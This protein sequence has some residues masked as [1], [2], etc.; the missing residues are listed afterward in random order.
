MLSLVSEIH[1]WSS[2]D[3]INVKNTDYGAFSYHLTKDVGNVYDSTKKS[4]CEKRGVAWNLT[5]KRPHKLKDKLKELDDHLNQSKI[6]FVSCK[7]AHVYLL[8]AK[9]ILV[10]ILY[11]VQTCDLISISFDKF[12]STKIQNEPVCDGYIDN[13]HIVAVLS[14]GRVF[15]YGGSWREGWSIEGG[16]RRYVYLYGE[17]MVV[18]GRS[19]AEHPQ[20]WSPLTKDHQRANLHLYWVGSRGSDLLSYKK[21]SAEPIA[22]VISKIYSKNLIVVEQNV[23]QRGAVSVE[24][25]VLELINNNLKRASVTAVPLQTQV[26]STS[27]SKNEIYLLLCCID[28]SIALLNRNRGSTKI[29][30][31]S[32]IPTLACWHDSNCL[33]AIGNENGQIQYIDASLNFVRTQIST[34]DF[35]PTNI[36]DVSSYFNTRPNVTLLKWEGKDL[37]LCLEHGPLI[38]VTHDRNSLHFLSVIQRYL[39]DGKTDKAVN[40]LLSWEFNEECFAALQKIVTYLLRLPLTEENAQLLQNALG[41]YYSPPIPLDAEAIHNY[42]FQVKCLTRRFFYQ[43]IRA[44][45]FETAFL[46]AVDIGHHDLFMDL[47]YIAVKMG[48]TEMA[49]AARAQASTLLSSCSS[50]ASD[51]SRSSC[52]QCSNSTSE[53]SSEELSETEDQPDVQI[54]PT[55][56]HNDNYLTT[57][58]NN[59]NP[60]T[61]GSYI[62]PIPNLDLPKVN[63]TK[64]TL[65]KPTTYRPFPSNQVPPLPVTAPPLPVPPV[66]SSVNEQFNNGTYQ[67]PQFSYSIPSVP[68][69]IQT[70]PF[71]FTIPNKNFRSYSFT[72]SN[73]ASESQKPSVVP[74]LPTQSNFNQHNY[75]QPNFPLPN[76]SSSYSNLSQ[77]TTNF[78]TIYTSPLT[79]SNSSTDHVS[80]PSSSPTPTTSQNTN[81]K[82]AQAKVKF[83][84]T[85]TAFIVPE[86][87][88]PVRPSL[89]AHVMDPQKELADSLPLC[90]PNED[91]LKDF[92][93]VKKNEN[94]ESPSPKI[95]VVHFGVV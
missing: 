6:L 63:F 87:K 53:S 78:P 18:W 32:F 20:P 82:K 61:Y 21:T 54:Q 51:C 49:A 59:S 91:Y 28:G 81:T 44:S 30:K 76:L 95:K 70:K 89:P 37:I 35:T 8:L 13:D 41:C 2:R 66:S 10:S 9:G 58:F 79:Y 24:V 11:N 7:D 84:D 14:D 17:Y 22:V 65:T 40:L 75:S 93:P 33:A 36:I 94:S 31:A 71:N 15:G 67:S 12:L 90:H 92:A 27:L 16:P 52:S 72:S 64:S 69:K 62:P 50:A 29:V 85:V 25:N 39:K 86:I 56:S 34:E 68:F 83:S 60:K 43:L 46:L 74:P 42:G 19:G 48:E 77:P 5:N 38:V 55:Q 80:R 26:C 47:H 23:S 88:R 57:N 1:F 3:D 45:M 4:Y 73:Y